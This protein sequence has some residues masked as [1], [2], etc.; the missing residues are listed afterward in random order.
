M[1]FTERIDDRYRRGFD[2]FMLALDHRFQSRQHVVG[3]HFSR[4]HLH[5]PFASESG[6]SRH[7]RHSIRAQIQKPE[8]PTARRS[9]TVQAVYI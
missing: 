8:R 3:K 1:S 6:R 2:R 7:W 9:V 4:V 5:H